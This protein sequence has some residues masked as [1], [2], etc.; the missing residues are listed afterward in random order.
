MSDNTWKHLLNILMNTSSID[1]T[2]NFDWI[3]SPF[4]VE[5]NDVAGRE[6]ELAELSVIEV[7][8]FFLN[9]ILFLFIYIMLVL[10]VTGKLVSCNNVFYFITY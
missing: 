9:S 1:S 6:E 10:I 7:E 2:E 4:E 5:M 3:R 8:K